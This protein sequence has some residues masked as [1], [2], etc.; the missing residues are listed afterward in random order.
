MRTV[1]NPNLLDGGGNLATKSLAKLQKNSLKVFSFALSSKH[2]LSSFLRLM[3]EIVPFLEGTRKDFPQFLW[4]AN[5]FFKFFFVKM[6]FLLF[7]QF[8]CV[9]LSFFI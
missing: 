2:I 1:S 3:F 8:H 4:F 9:I 5:I 6:T 7:Y